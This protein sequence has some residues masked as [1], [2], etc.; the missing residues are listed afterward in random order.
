MFPGNLAN[1]MVQ[2]ECK[3][4]HWRSHMKEN[5]ELQPANS[6]TCEWGL[7][8]PSHTLNSPTLHWLQPQEQAQKKSAEETPAE[9]SPNCQ[10]IKPIGCGSKPRHFRMVCCTGEAN[11]TLY[12]ERDMWVH[13]RSHWFPENN[14][15]GTDIGVVTTCISTAQILLYLPKN[16]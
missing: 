7:R 4:A 11:C 3:W 5:K 9:L 12:L 13:K 15:L 1:T 6:P 14:H 16:H 10:P 2:R 8:R